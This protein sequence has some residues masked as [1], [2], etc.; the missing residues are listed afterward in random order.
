MKGYLL[1]DNDGC[2][3]AVIIDKEENPLEFMHNLT[4]AISEHYDVPKE[5]IHIS[6]IDYIDKFIDIIVNVG[7]VNTVDKMRCHMSVIYVY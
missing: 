2:A 6:R 3:I 5:H 4:T 1:E 7:D